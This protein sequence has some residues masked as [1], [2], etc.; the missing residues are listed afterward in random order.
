VHIAVCVKQVPDP[1]APAGTFY[2]DE[3]ANE[4]RWSPPA[5]QLIST[6]DLHAVEA[7]VQLKE[8]VGGHIT[9]LSL[10]DPSADVALRRALAAGCD[11]AVRIEPGAA[12]G[13]D[14]LA[15]ARAL[16]AAIVEPGDVAAVFC[17]RLAADWDM[18]H[19]APM[20]AELLGFAMVTPVIG[21][22]A[23]EEG[24]R[25]RKL[26]DEGHQVLDVPLPAVLA[27]SN[28]LN[29]PRYPTMRS[30]L[31]AQRK[32]V[33]VIDARPGVPSAEPLV[34]LRRLKGLDLT[35]ACEFVEGETVEEAGALLA[36]LLVDRGLVEG[37]PA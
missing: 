19:V 34:S 10:G 31:D 12:P 15:V 4:P 14:R 26:T 16:A 7:A 33:R 30:V 9:V 28:E 32:A 21:V 13:G 6:F 11:D 2:V 23:G 27:V 8:A 17:G 29:E 35:R 36:G 18:G 24:L 25:V 37:R 3:A 5:Q 1:Q 20:L 22:A